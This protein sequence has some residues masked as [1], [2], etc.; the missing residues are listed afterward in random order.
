VLVRY[1][2]LNVLLASMFRPPALQLKFD[3][4]FPFPVKSPKLSKPTASFV[5]QLYKANWKN[6]II[7]VAGLNTLRY[8]FAA[9]NAFQ[10][11]AVDNSEESDNLFLVSL[12]L[13]AMY[14]IASVIE[15]YGVVS[16]SMQRLNM[17]RIYLYFALVAC[18]MVVSAGVLNGISYFTFADELMLECVSLATEGRG[19]QK[20]L[21]RDR[22][23]PVSVFPLA[24]YEARKQCVYAWVHQSWFQVSS[25]F[26]FSVFPA[27]IYFGLVYTYYRQTVNRNHSACLINTYGDDRTNHRSAPLGR[28]ETYPQVGYTIQRN[29]D[30]HVSSRNGMTSSR[31]E[32]AHNLFSPRRRTTTQVPKSMRGV[33]VVSIHQSNN[34]KA[35]N[36]VKKK[37]PFVSRSLKR[38][39]RPPPLI[40]SPSPIGLSPGPPSYRPSKVYAAFAAPVLS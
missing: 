40:Q 4:R 11:A 24:V 22:P 39:H 9:H 20:S 14:I 19:Y 38:D 3:N 17:I 12:A 25:V 32:H 30:T 1:H 21:F 36:P 27:M 15:I 2:V 6:P 31:L 37:P 13:G 16:V 23:W 29:N 5:S 33:G 7:A 18:V 26:L 34:N 10:D 35:G 28:M 8:V